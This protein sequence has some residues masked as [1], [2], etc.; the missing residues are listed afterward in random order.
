MLTYVSVHTYNLNVLEQSIIGLGLVNSLGWLVNE[1]Q[2][3]SW[4][5]D[6]RD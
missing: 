3:S 6:Y 4:H 2:G 5:W 1:L